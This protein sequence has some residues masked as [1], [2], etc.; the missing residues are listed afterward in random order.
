MPVRQANPLARVR[1]WR[2]VI[3]IR[4]ASR[5]WLGFACAR[6]TRLE[7]ASQNDGRSASP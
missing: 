1:R 3:L 5:P 6:T 4:L 7:P 2:L